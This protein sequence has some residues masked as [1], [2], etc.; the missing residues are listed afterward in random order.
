M[1]ALFTEKAAMSGLIFF[2]CPR[3]TN[4]SLGLKEIIDEYLGTYGCYYIGGRLG[5]L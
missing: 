3:P 4:S 5:L 1:P 2:S